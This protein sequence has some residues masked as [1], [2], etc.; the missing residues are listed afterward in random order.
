VTV[1]VDRGRTATT[2][3]A[4]TWA[5]AVLLPWVLSRGA[6]Y[7]LVTR[8]GALRGRVGAAAF[9]LWDGVWYLRIA[10]DGYGFTS[11]RGETPYPFFPLLPALLRGADAL[12]IPPIV[13]GVVLTHLLFL[14]ALAG[15]YAITRAHGTTR[16]AAL[17]SWS[18]ALF[19]GSAP[20]TLLYPG[21]IF[22]ACSV[23]AFRAVEL[24]RD[25][26]A[27]ALLAAA[28]LARP[29]G[30]V[31]T[32]ACGFAALRS[33]G[34]RRALRVIVPPGVAVLLWIGW[35]R[36]STGDALVFVH[37]K[38]AWHEVTLAS[39]VAGTDPIPKLDLAPLALAVVLLALAWRRLPGAWLLLAALALLPSLGLGMLGMPRYASSCFPV[40]VAAGIVLARLPRGARVAVLAGSAVALLYVAQ[41]ILVMGQMP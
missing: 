22:L 28:A 26:A 15:V 18:L 4:T 13:A 19:P 38:A 40:L 34:S 23:W 17:A 11:P 20:L 3:L 39:L 7:V 24:R 2:R 37:A 1:A 33:G 27:A 29:N 14:A 10:R 9:P 31:A 25:D 41:R 12:G 8:A 21:A 30:L 6:L 16:E 35:L 5:G 36:W 32:I